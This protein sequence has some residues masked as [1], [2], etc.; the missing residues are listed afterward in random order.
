MWRFDYMS[1]YPPRCEAVGQATQS[2]VAN[3]E[4]EF[5]IETRTVLGKTPHSCSSE[6][7]VEFHGLQSSSFLTGQVVKTQLPAR[8][9]CQP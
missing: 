4:M 6:F 8:C 2:A 5:I 9:R 3:E 7:T 1:A